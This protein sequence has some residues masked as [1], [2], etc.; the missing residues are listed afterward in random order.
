M[1]QWH[2]IMD[3]QQAGPVDDATLRRWIAEGRIRPDQLVWCEGMVEWQ[4]AATVP[5]LL[6][7]PIPPAFPENPENLEDR[8]A[9][10]PTEGTYGAAGIGKLLGQGWRV[11]IRNFTLLLVTMLVVTAL[12]SIPEILHR[13]LFPLNP[14]QQ[15]LLSFFNL[16]WAI[17]IVL[18]IAL[19]MYAFSL[20]L[21]C[22]QPARVSTVFSGFQLFGKAIGLQLWIGLLVLLWS[23]LLIVPGIIAALRYSQAMF[24]M[25]YKP[26]LGINE[27]V[28]VSS[29][30]M[31]GNK[32][33]LF[34]LWLV[35]ILISII[36]LAPFWL[37]LIGKSPSTMEPGVSREIVLSTP[38]WI[39]S[40]VAPILMGMFS[41]PVLAEFHR[42]LTPHASSMT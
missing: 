3:G 26:H 6:D 10:P 5:G 27:S 30:I 24:L 39:W 8:L 32:G 35:L 14:S 28:K 1:T 40:L 7:F 15:I 13:C 34:C 23:L 9:D 11:M 31:R 21:V 25:T 19:G 20:R 38:I 16:F 29:E 37:E 33:R 36:I 17:C 41:W 2:Y 4:A 12:N 18:P 42:D 22:G